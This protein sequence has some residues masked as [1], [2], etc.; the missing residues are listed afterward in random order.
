C[1][2]RRTPSGHGTA[3]AGESPSVVSSRLRNFLCRQGRE[4]KPARPQ[5]ELLG[6]VDRLQILEGDLV[7]EALWQSRS[8]NTPP[9]RDASVRQSIRLSIA[10]FL[11]EVILC[12]PAHMCCIPTGSRQTKRCKQPSGLAHSLV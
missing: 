7:G 5:P 4:R 2:L 3:L 1:T 8:L 10:P 9:P 6:I 11:N 12:S